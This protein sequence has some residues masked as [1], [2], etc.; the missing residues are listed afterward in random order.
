[1]MEKTDKMDVQKRTRSGYKLPSTNEL[2]SELKRVNERKRFKTTLRS[3][4]FTR[5][6]G[7]AGEHPG[8]VCTPPGITI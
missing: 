7:T 2:E 1:M 8:A 6:T 4:I 5:G 3:T